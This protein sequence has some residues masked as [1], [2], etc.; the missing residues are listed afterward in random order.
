MNPFR[1]TQPHTSANDPFTNLKQLS[2]AVSDKEV[3][4]YQ[5]LKERPKISSLNPSSEKGTI[6][7]SSHTESHYTNLKLKVEISKLYKAITLNVRKQTKSGTPYEAPLGKVWVF[8]GCYIE[9]SEEVYE[10][11]INFK[12]FY[13]KLAAKDYV[14]GSSSFTQMITLIASTETGVR[15]AINGHG[16]TPAAGGTYYHWWEVTRP[17]ISL[18][19]QRKREPAS[20]SGGF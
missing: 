10:N 5:F 14:V 19:P 8:L 12:D 1:V 7:G 9:K 3:L 18:Y 11:F 13:R 2:T 4:K 20:L 15:V 17:P 6:R 16:P